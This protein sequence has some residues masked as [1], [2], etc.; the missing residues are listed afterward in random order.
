MPAG[1]E[2][3][4]YESENISYLFNDSITLFLA[5]PVDESK[6]VTILTDDSVNMST[7]DAN[8]PQDAMDAMP[9]IQEEE[10]AE[11]Q[12]GMPDEDNIEIVLEVDLNRFM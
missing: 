7:Q 5:S 11:I 6:I 3:D 2:G 10:D 9:G 4:E 8:L 12:E 1:A